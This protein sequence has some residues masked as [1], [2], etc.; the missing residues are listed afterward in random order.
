MEKGKMELQTLPFYN[1]RIA[2]PPSLLR[3]VYTIIHQEN[4]CFTCM[5][6]VLMYLR[7]I[8]ESISAITVDANVNMFDVIL[9]RSCLYPSC[10]SLIIFLLLLM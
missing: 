8:K 6:V 2:R 5:Q 9:A 7:C 1:I 3:S 4:S 10:I